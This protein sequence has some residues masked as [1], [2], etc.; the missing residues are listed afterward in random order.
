MTD[1]LLKKMVY[2]MDSTTLQ[3]C[4]CVKITSEVIAK[5]LQLDVHL[6]S[7]AAILHD[8]GNNVI[9]QD[10]LQKADQLFNYEREAIDTL[11]YFGY[12][13]LREN[14]VD[15]NICL[16]VLFHRGTD[17]PFITGTKPNYPEELRQYIE[18]LRTADAYEAL[19]AKRPYRDAYSPQQA[20]SIL[21]NEGKFYSPALQILAKREHVSM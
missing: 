19:T 2:S 14:G 13:I 6:M 5:H 10:L 15:E 21:I 7:N 12:R 11:P 17:K 3:H 1:A 9:Q 4:M 20:I 16:I 18:S 8:I